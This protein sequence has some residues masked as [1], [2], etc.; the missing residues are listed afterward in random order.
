MR[1]PGVVEQVELDLALLRSTVRLTAHRS[2]TAQRVQL[3]E[4]AEEL[5]VHLRAELDFVEEAHNTELVR[6]L[7]EP[8]DGLVVPRVIRP[9]VT[10]RALVLELIAGRKVDAGHGLEPERAGLLAR[11]FFRAYV[12]QVVVEGVY[13]ADPHRGNVLLTDDGRLA[14]LDFGLLGRLDE[15]TRAGL[16]LLLLAV[17][18]NRADDVAELVV[19]LSLTTTRLRPGGLRAGRPAQAAALPPPPARVDP[20]GSG[21]RR[22]AAGGDPAGH[23][24]PDLIRSGGQDARAGRLDRPVPRPGARPRRADR[25]AVARGDDARG[26]APAGA[27]PARRLRLHAAGAARR[28][29]GAPRPRRLRARAGNI[30]GRRR[31]HGPGRARGQPPLDRKPRRAR[32]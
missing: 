27:E 23:P 20:G 8:F 4:L 3:E 2:E 32:R 6:G 16:A 1:R 21:A 7:V 12:F 15:D 18:Q 31:P 17:A 26:R 25:G 10:E 28:P 14:L 30:D 5:E 22:P 13:H 19:S 29:P 9:Y 11:E 24:A